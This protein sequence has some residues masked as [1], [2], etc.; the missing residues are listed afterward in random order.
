MVSHIA[1]FHISLYGRTVDS[2][3]G[4]R[5][6]QRHAPELLLHNPSPFKV[7]IAITKFNNKKSPGSDQIPAEL[8]QAGGEIL[9]SVFYKLITSI[10]YRKRLAD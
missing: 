6:V 4:S 1:D 9:V 5:Q 10:W 3:S 7:E 2:A 8:I